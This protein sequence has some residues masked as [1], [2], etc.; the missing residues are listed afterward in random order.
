MTDVEP[1]SDLR[2]GPWRLRRVPWAGLGLIVDGLIHDQPGLAPPA[3]YVDAVLL[4]ADHREAFFALIDRAGLVVCRDV[5]G[6]DGTH[7]E[8]RGRSSRGRMSQSELYHHDGCSGPEKPRVV[9]IRCPHQIVPRAIATAV[10]PFA[11]VVHGMLL[12]LSAELR[13]ADP[14]VVAWHATL[15][16]DGALAAEAYDLAQGAINRIVRLAMDAES[17]RA[18][19]RAVDERAGAYREPWTMGESR[20]IANAN[21][22]LTM[23]HRRAYLE[24]PGRPSG[25][26]VKRWPAGPAM[27]D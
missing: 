5:V 8:V 9:E 2:F 18:F 25:H 14:E 11:A 21:R 27:H 13:A 26:L 12:E 19:Y 16:A 7:A 1:T 4:T 6:V 22:G 3:A 10:A 17:A 15:I 24:P 23:Q 20:F